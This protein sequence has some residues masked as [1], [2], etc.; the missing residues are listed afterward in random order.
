MN[1]QKS[2]QFPPDQILVGYMEHNKAEAEAEGNVYYSDQ[3]FIH[4]S[5]HENVSTLCCGV[6]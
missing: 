5:I 4:R 6:Y 1:Q 2:I 3:P